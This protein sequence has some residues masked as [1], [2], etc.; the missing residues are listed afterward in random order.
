MRGFD[1]DG[2][3]VTDDFVPLRVVCVFIACSSDYALRFDACC[4]STFAI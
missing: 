3:T 1:F 4:F 2:T